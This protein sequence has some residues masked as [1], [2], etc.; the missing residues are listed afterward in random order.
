MTQA[1]SLP[2]THGRDSSETD[3]TTSTRWRDHFL[4][5]LADTSNVTA[6]ARHAGVTPARA[7][8]TRRRDAG[9]AHAWNRALLEGYEN[10]EMETLCRLRFGSGK[11]EPKADIANALRLLALHRSSAATQKARAYAERDE[12]AVLDA[13][14][15]KIE[16]MRKR[17][18]EARRKLNHR[19][20]RDAADAVMTAQPQALDD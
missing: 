19:R 18:A 5:A 15:A 7:Y 10:L 12:Q 16:T 17:E 14:N 13:I 2:I 11:D 20:K 1:P 9:F 3:S 6:A 8:D 4:D